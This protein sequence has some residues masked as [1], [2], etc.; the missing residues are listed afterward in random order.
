[1]VREKLTISHHSPELGKGKA[2]GRRAEN[3]PAGIPTKGAGTVSSLGPR[4]RLG[5]HLRRFPDHKSQAEGSDQRR[6]EIAGA[7]FKG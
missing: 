5:K 1:M 3:I 2:S 4:Q 7:T 6:K